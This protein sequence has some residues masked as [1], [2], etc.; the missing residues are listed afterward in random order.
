M[1]G[2]II[3]DPYMNRLASISF[4]GGAAL[5]AGT[6]ALGV[7]VVKAAKKLSGSEEKSD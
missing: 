3:Y 2:G 6:I 5:M 1:I 4:F 7:T